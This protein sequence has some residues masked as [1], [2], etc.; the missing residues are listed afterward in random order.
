MDNIFFDNAKKEERKKRTNLDSP[1]SIEGS[2][3]VRHV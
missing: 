1:S 3:I 2:I